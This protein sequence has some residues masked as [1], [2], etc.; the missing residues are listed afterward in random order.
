VLVAVVAVL[1]VAIALFVLG[2]VLTVVAIWHAIQALLRGDL[3]A[4]NLTVEFLEIVSVM[5]KA[6]IFYI[7]GVGFYSLFV[8]PL[9]LPVA[10]GVETLNDLETKVVSVVVVIMAVTFLEHFILWERPDELL[11][12][13]ITL[14]VVVVALVAFQVYS[15]WSKEEALRQHPESQREAQHQLFEEGR[16]KLDPRPDVDDTGPAD[17]R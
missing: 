13:G 2:A 11:Q 1:L 16:T 7:I 8:A 15:H 9:N 4:T 12:F 5:L 3:L 17:Q 10:L 14:A 6:V